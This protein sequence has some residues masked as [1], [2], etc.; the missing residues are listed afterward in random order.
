MSF[1][2][3]LKISYNEMIIKQER[4]KKD[5]LIK[6]VACNWNVKGLFSGND[7]AVEICFCAADLKPISLPVLFADFRFSMCRVKP[8]AL[9]SAVF[10]ACSLYCSSQMTMRR[11]RARRRHRRKHNHHLLQRRAAKTE[12]VNSLETNTIW[13]PLEYFKTGAEWLCLVDWSVWQCL[14]TPYSLISGYFALQGPVNLSKVFW[15]GF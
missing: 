8:S 12:T 11:K 9:A 7:K 10:S 2:L 15:R 13:N 1:H 5:S 6:K 3:Q 4:T 14:W